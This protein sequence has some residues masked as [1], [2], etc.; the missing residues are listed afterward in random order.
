MLTCKSCNS[1]DLSDTIRFGSFPNSRNFTKAPNLE[2]SEHQIDLIL[3]HDCGLIFMLNEPDLK[4]LYSSEFYSTA[5]QKP[6][7]IDDFIAT[8]L[9]LS[10]AGNALD[11]GCNDGALMLKLNENGYNTVGIEPN[12]V[13]AKTAKKRGLNL[14]VGFFNARMATKIMSK[15][16]KFDAIFLRHVLEH[17]AD[18]NGFITDALTVLNTNGLLCIELPDVDVGLASGNP[19]VVWEEHL[20]YFTRTYLKKFF[21]EHGLKLLAYREYVFG[22]GAIAYFLKE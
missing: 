12:K 15:Y 7:H 22:G 5:F 19:V 20:N 6:K 14:E 13:P 21:D 3:C 4:A 18:P 2:P 16:G 9:S 1:H 10:D 17:A 8:A 11:I